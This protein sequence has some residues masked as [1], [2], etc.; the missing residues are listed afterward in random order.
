M[1]VTFAHGTASM[2]SVPVGT[3][4]RVRK[5]VVAAIASSTTPAALARIM[6]AFPLGNVAVIPDTDRAIA[7]PTAS[8]IPFSRV[9][10]SGSLGFFWTGTFAGCFATGDFATGGTV[11]GFAAGGIVAG[12]AACVTG[13]GVRLGAT[14]VGSETP[15]GG[16]C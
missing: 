1:A 11:A 15:D 2:T 8:E 10:K 16:S 5:Y 4:P 12:F 7:G 3:G 9:M 14:I 6:R 13:G